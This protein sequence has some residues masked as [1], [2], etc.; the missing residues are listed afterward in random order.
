MYKGVLLLIIGSYL[1][2]QLEIDENYS[3]FRATDQENDED[4]KENSEEIVELIF[5]N[6]LRKKKILIN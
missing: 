3:Y 2:A 4:E 1:S 6:S 5:P